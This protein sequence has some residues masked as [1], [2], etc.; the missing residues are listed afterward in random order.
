MGV[1][2][3]PYAKG[4]VDADAIV[5]IPRF[6]CWRSRSEVKVHSI[7]AKVILGH[8]EN[9][10]SGL[11]GNFQV[12]DLNIDDFEAKTKVTRY[13]H[14]A[15]ALLQTVI[16]AALETVPEV[17]PPPPAKSRLCWG[18]PDMVRPASPESAWSAARGRWIL[19]PGAST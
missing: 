17:A 12:A 15:C 14:V 10:S 16:V 3:D 2:A 9:L 8:W 4:G 6:D 13:D 18:T 7:E 1:T 19:A 11:G 5:C